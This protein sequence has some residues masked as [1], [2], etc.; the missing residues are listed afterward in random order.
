[1]PN[2]SLRLTKSRREILLTLENNSGALT[3]ALIHSQ[4]PHLNIVTIY[5]NLEYF[6]AAGLIKK[7]HLGE[8]EAYFEL[9]ETPH[10]HALC[11]K[12]NR[13]IHFSLDD[14]VLLKHFKF[15]DF[16]ITDLEITVRG[17]CTKHKNLREKKQVSKTKQK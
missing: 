4:L 1:M 11:S 10:H 8:T 2:M 3:A 7:L 6:V 15:S 12:C 5:R 13:V 9:Q 17:H 16:S 14:K